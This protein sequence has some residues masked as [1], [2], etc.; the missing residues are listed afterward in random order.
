MLSQLLQP[1]SLCVN[2]RWGVDNTDAS[3]GDCGEIVPGLQ[4]SA[5][6]PP[7]FPNKTKMGM[8]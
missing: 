1:V 4:A 3:K 7:P 8:G 5:P 2:V 6:T